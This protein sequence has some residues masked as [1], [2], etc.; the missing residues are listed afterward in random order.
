[1]ERLR[2]GVILLPEFI[3]HLQGLCATR[4]DGLL[5]A[6]R[7]IDTQNDIERRGAQLRSARERLARVVSPGGKG[8]LRV[9]SSLEGVVTEIM[10]AHGEPV[11][12][13]QVLLRIGGEHSRWVR[14]RFVARPDEPLLD[15]RAV[16]V[17]T[18]AGK[19]LDLKGRA[20]LLSTHPTVDPRTQLATFIAEVSGNDH[21]EASH[22]LRTGTH[23]VLLIQVGKKQERLTVPR[24][25]VNDINTRRYVFVQTGGEEF[26]M[27]RVVVGASDGDFVHVVS[28]VEEGERV[29]TK[30]GYDVHL[31]SV[32][33]QVE[34]HRH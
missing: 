26:E 27:R 24:S 16:A 6:K 15:A 1:M 8:G 22:E 4:E 2:C 28:G 10:V 34:S 14:A 25:A 32:M 9:K 29:V 7:V 13:G 20:R 12:P 19:R 3:E 23:V 21:D 17:R 18:A 33:G 5:P 30:G 31:S 11:E